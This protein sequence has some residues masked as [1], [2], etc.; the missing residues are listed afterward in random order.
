MRSISQLTVEFAAC[1]DKLSALLM[2]AGRSA[3]RYENLALLYPQS[4]MLQSYFA[5]YFLVVVRL[6]H[7]ILKFTQRSLF[8]Q[9]TSFLSNSE[10]KT[11]QSQFNKWADLIRDEV[12]MVMA[13]GIEEQKHRL[14]T[15]L[16]FSEFESSA[17]S[18][19]RRL[20]VLDACSKY[21]YQKTWKSVRKEGRSTVFSQCA[22]YDTWV[23]QEG[24]ST[25]IFTGILGCGK[26]VMLANIVD[27]LNLN[28]QDN[29]ATVAYFFC[30]YDLPKSLTA[31]A[32]LGSLARQLFCRASCD[33]VAR[34][35][36]SMDAPDLDC[37]ALA[38]LLQSHLSPSRRVFF[39]L[40]G[41]DECDQEERKLLVGYLKQLQDS[42]RIGIC[43]SVRLEANKLT[44]LGPNL[45][46]KPTI[47][48]MPK[49]NLD[50]RSFITAKLEEVIMSGSLKFGDPAIVLEIQD[51]LV[52]GAHGM[53][54]W[55]AL[56]FTSLCD[57]KTDEGIRHTLND[58]PKDLP[59]TFSRIL[60]KAKRL[61]VNYQTRIL[62]LVT[63]ARRP[64]ITEELREALSVLP[65]N[66]KWDSAQRIHDIYQVLACCGS[67]LVVDEEDSSVRLVHHS[68]LR[69][70]QNEKEYT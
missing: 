18:M 12:R 58:L 6:C 28:F 24:S 45:L 43:L 38:N 37:E 54:L 32:V 48:P 64:L 44:S 35:L 2:D 19:R 49:Q 4:R 33:E 61:G 11:Y 23:S 56:Q 25:L 27:S 26:S 30:R 10:S 13:R 65:G 9:L 20:R 62:Q 67:L 57:A 15:L 3:P 50:I 40:D 66:T 59:E 55:V 17:K 14:H 8:G 51:A 53:F 60:R 7:Q 31:R 68:V 47:T 46:A 5:E 52:N 29:G 34:Q 41:V 1:L 39:V 16:K 70:L 63:A 42:L 69:F 21:D 22:E 36:D